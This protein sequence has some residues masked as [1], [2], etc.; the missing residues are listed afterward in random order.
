MPSPLF[1]ISFCFYFC[2]SS[3]FRL[4]FSSVRMPRQTAEITRSIKYP[5]T[6]LSSPVFTR[7]LL[8]ELCDCGELEDCDEFDDCDESSLS[9]PVSVSYTH[10]FHWSSLEIP[11]FRFR[12]RTEKAEAVPVHM[13]ASCQPLDSPVPQTDRGFPVSY[14]HLDVYKRQAKWSW[15]K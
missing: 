12:H 15:M 5:I 1:N 9:S 7:S 10:L 14:T 2:D 8:S 11:A 4:W 6:G 3:F 13:A